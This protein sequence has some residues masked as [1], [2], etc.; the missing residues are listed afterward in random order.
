M[1]FRLEPAPPRHVLTVRA[2][3]VDADPEQWRRLR[4]L[5]DESVDVAIEA[6]GEAFG[7]PV[8]TAQRLI[9]PILRQYGRSDLK[10]DLGFGRRTLDARKYPLFDALA[11]VGALARIHRG[12][13]VIDVEVEA[14]STPDPATDYPSVDP[15][16]VPTADLSSTT[17][18]RG[19]T[20]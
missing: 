3:L 5:T 10:A 13:H 4:L 20:E 18:D 11:E 19:P 15:A 9:T 16:A 17:T 7:L 2:T 1:R 14:I 6:I 8:D 12:A